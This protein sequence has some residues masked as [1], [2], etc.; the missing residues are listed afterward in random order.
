M[1]IQFIN[2][3]GSGKLVMFQVKVT[4]EWTTFELLPFLVLG[5]CGGLIGAAFIKSIKLLGHLRKKCHVIRHPILEVV[6][7]SIIT[8]ALSDLN[9]FTRHQVLT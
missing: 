7:I 6:V 1:I 9:D 2:P 4:E 5:I 3:L 8:A